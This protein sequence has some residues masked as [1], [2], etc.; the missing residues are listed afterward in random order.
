MFLYYHLAWKYNRATPTGHGKDGASHFHR[1]RT[2]QTCALLQ[3]TPFAASCWARD[4][5]IFPCVLSIACA[6][7]RGRATSGQIG[8]RG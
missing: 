3:Q 5:S 2:R 6:G 1:R 7:T 8:A 4:R